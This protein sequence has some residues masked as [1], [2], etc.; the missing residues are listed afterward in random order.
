MTLLD[1]DTG[2]TRYSNFDS[3]W[4]AQNIDISALE[5]GQELDVWYCYNNEYRNFLKVEVV[6]QGPF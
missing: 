6:Q 5:E 1:S 2:H 3:V 4:D